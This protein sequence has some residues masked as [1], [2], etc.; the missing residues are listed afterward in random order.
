MN[1]FVAY[2][3]PIKGLKQGLHQFKFKIDSAFFALFEGSPIEVGEIDFLVDSL[4]DDKTVIG[5]RMMGGGFG[6]CTIN[7]VHEDAIEGLQERLAKAYQETMGHKLGMYMVVT[8]D[9]ANVQT[10]S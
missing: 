10:L 7:L 9:G 1:A 6:G 2:S 4:S 3:I 5:A 8:G